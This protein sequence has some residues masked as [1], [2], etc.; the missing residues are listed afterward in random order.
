MNLYHAA[1]YTNKFCEGRK[2]Y[3]TLTDRERE[4]RESVRN[5]LESY[6][7]VHKKPFVD[8]MRQNGAKVFLD[9]GAFS[10]HTL[11]VSIDLPGY[12]KYIQENQDILRVDDGIVMASVLDGIGDAQQTYDNQRHMEYLGVRPLPCFHSGEDSRYLD[13]YVQNYEYITLG[14]MVGAT[15]DQLIVWLD[16]IWEHHLTDGSGRARLKVHGFGITAVPIMERYPWHS[17]DSSSWLQSAN[18][19]SI[20]TPEFGPISVSEKSPSRFTAGQHIDT[21]RGIEREKLK[22]VITTQ[23]YDLNR[24]ATEYAARWAYNCWSYGQIEDQINARKP[25]V[26]KATVQEL[27]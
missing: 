18:F 8:L 13:W 7:Y 11:G 23:G 15:T 5:I 6:H 12:C 10:A 19:G 1:I 9:S 17:V 26:F 22:E 25:E 3:M 20:V 2:E 21:M 4:G 16:R 14:G 27:F 24:L